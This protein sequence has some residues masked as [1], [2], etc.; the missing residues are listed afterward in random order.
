MRHLYSYILAAVAA[1]AVIVACSKPEEGSGDRDIPPSI[2]PLEPFNLMDHTIVLDTLLRV[3]SASGLMKDELPVGP[4]KQGIDLHLEVIPV[5]AYG[6]SE[7]SGDYYAVSGYVVAHNGELNVA[8]QTRRYSDYDYEWISPFMGNL[9]LEAALLDKDSN[10]VNKG[11]VRFQSTPEPSTTIGSMTYNK[12]FTMSF[13]FGITF[14][15]RREETGWRLTL[16]PSLLPSFN[17]SNSSTQIL[18]D[19]TVEMNTDGSTREVSYDIKTNK[20]ATMNVDAI[21]SHA[22]SDQKIEFSWI[23]FVPK[24]RLSSI[25]YCTDALQMRFRITPGY[26]YNYCYEKYTGSSYKMELFDIPLDCITPAEQRT[27]TVELGG[28]NRF[29]VGTLDFANATSNYVTGI[30]L[31]ST[32]TGEEKTISGTYSRLKHMSVNLCAGEY[33]LYYTIKNGDTLKVIGNYVIDGI[34]IDGCSTFETSTLKG[35]KLQ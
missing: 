31:V 6:D 10:E 8:R 14:G 20:S 32:A 28:L 35:T 23:W 11:D 13:N 21:P 4:V 5:Y 25:D 16:F 1:L 7:Y 27:A 22:R 2:T 18:P 26:R 15:K 12:G 19:Q 3:E 9:G 17:W 30:K 29:P 24:G 34:I 33:S